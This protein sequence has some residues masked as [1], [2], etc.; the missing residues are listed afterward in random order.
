MAVYVDPMFTTRRCGTWPYDTACHLFGNDL[1]ELL[2]FGGRLGM[3]AAWMRECPIPHFRLTAG[4]R[5]EAIR[6]GAVAITSHEWRSRARL[7]GG[8][9]GQMTLL[10]EQGD[11]GT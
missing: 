6:A 1:G 10:G 9:H 3:E 11:E 5:A 8:D 2:A 7:R 4:K